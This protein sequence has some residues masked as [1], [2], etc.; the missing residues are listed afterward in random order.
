LNKLFKL[1]EERLQKDMSVERLIKH[2]R[3][4]R[5]LVKEE[6]MNDEKKFKIENNPKNII[7]IESGEDEF[8]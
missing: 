5:I 7:D 4:L 1:G 3:D 6:M 8:I 2:L